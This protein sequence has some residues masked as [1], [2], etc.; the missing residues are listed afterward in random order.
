MVFFLPVE[1]MNCWNFVNCLSAAPYNL[2]V[3]KF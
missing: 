1:L 2:H 3:Q